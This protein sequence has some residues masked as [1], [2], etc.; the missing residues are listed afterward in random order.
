MGKKLN[1][2]LESLK[3]GK[4]APET[5]RIYHLHRRKQKEERTEGGFVM[6][7]YNKQIHTQSFKIQD[8]ATVYQAEIEAI[9]QACKYMDDNYDTIKPKNVKMLTDSQAALKALGSIDFRSTMA[10]KTAEALENLKWRTKGCSIAWV[11]AQLWTVGNEAA[12]AAARQGAENIDKKL[13]TINTPIPGETAKSGID[14][15]IR[16]EWKRNGKMHPIKNTLN[17]STAG[18]TKT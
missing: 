12:D 7:N 10:L 4:K 1:L 6:Y 18:L 14:N 9:Y 16:K 15:A 13:K 8:H 2:N 17:T 3:G 11:K 5:L